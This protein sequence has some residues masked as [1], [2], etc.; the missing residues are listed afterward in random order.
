MK[1]NL[2][3]IGALVLL[4]LIV[5]VILLGGVGESK[6]AKP[7][8]YLYPEEETRVSVKLDYDGTLTSTYPAYENGWTVDASP[9]GTLTDPITGRQ[10]YCLFWEGVTDRQYDF[11]QG[12]CVARED[13]A[14][15]LEEALAELGLTEREAN[16]FI[17]YWLPRLEE[18]PYNL[19]SFQ[20]SAYT[21]GAELT[22]DPA[23]DTLIRVFMAWRGLE[24]PVEVVPQTLTAPER[25]GFT[26]VEWGG[27]EVR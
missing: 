22:I 1:R 17:I 9:D 27:A 24:E 23:P 7:V 2:P 19:I 14:A 12:F 4:A 26:A 13:T 10:Y 6:S 21:D 8:I 25:T 5:G 3:I 20:T 15:F 11:S 18:N 16:E